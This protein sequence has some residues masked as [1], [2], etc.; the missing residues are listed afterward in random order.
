MCV[1]ATLACSAAA[2]GAIYPWAYMPL[3]AASAILGVV[4]LIWGRGPVPW[5]LIASLALVALAVSLQ[6]VPLNE[7]T[8]A[9]LSPRAL[10]IHRQRDLAAAVGAAASFPLSIDPPQTRL[11]LMF[12]GAFAL[13]LAGTARMLSGH[14]A[15]QVAASLAV[16]GVALAIVGLVQR[17]TFNGK[18]YG[19]WEL[20]QGGSPFGP[21]INRNH[22]AG[23]MLMVVPLTVGLFACLVSRR[24]AGVGPHWRARVLWFASTNANKAILAAFAV[25]TM[26][27]ALV[28]TLSRSGITAFVGAMAFAS[29]VLLTRRSGPARGGRRLVAAYLTLVSIIVVSW[30]GVDRIAARFTAPRSIGVEGRLAIWADSWRMVEDFPLAGTGLN[31]FGSAALFYQQSLKG[32]HM[33]EAHND[34]L[35]LAAEGGALVGVPIVLSGAVLVATIRRRFRDDVGSILWIRVGAITGLLA[36]AA[37]SLVEFSLQMPANA[38]LFAVLCGIALHDSGRVAARPLPEVAELDAS[39]PRTPTPEASEKVVTFSRAQR[40]L[41]FSFDEPSVRAADPPRQFEP[42]D[43]PDTQD[44]EKPL[45]RHEVR[46]PRPAARSVRAPAP[47]RGIVGLVAILSL[48][49]LLLIILGVFGS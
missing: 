25:M 47:A 46:R 6:L 37:Q 11:A 1:V 16:V 45:L 3:V 24:M 2:F 20:A 35:Q 44:R 34:Y 43:L 30:V 42:S 36:I 39:E 23:W 9:S 21:F 49:L 27:L 38:A 28:V 13:L 48:I 18:I 8:L 40:P 15:R 17:A 4:G 10:D 7:D 29:V 19:F 32:S 22:F 14:S 12:L 41:D 26:A 31:T 33:R 5:P